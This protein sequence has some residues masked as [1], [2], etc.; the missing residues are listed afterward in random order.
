MKFKLAAFALATLAA[1]SA[2][3]IDGLAPAKPGSAPAAPAAPLQAPAN[4]G[5]VAN[6]PNGNA[7]QRNGIQAN[8]LAADDSAYDKMLY[9]A[10]ESRDVEG[11]KDAIKSGV[12]L[13]Q[14]FGVA[15]PLFGGNLAENHL[16][17][18]KFFVIASPDAGRMSLANVPGHCTKQHLAHA[19]FAASRAFGYGNGIP[20]IATLF[21]RQQ[22]LASELPLANAN[23]RAQLDGEIEAARA[24]Q[25]A[26]F[27]I[28]AL[29]DANIPV[30]DKAF[31]PAYM[32]LNADSM[33]HARLIDLWML[34]KY[35]QA[36]PEIRRARGLKEPSRIAWDAFKAKLAGASGSNPNLPTQYEAAVFDPAA[37]PGGDESATI[38]SFAFTSFKWIEREGPL[39]TQLELCDIEKRIE[40]SKRP[41][42]GFDGELFAAREEFLTDSASM[43]SRK[44]LDAKPFSAFQA[45]ILKLVPSTRGAG[46]LGDAWAQGADVYVQREFVAKLLSRQD[47]VDAM[48]NKTTVP[49]SGLPPLAQLIDA[50]NAFGSPALLRAILE[51]GVNPGLKGNDGKTAADVAMGSGDPQHIW[52]AQAF[53]KKDFDRSGC[54]PSR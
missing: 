15:C 40:M 28:L 23:A 7:I 51:A 41:P 33:S 8:Q 12:N 52:L 10:I 26:S 16:F 32:G 29:L 9:A 39:K 2:M 35:D 11:V 43:L 1:G 38:K 50:S 47:V 34:S 19:Y 54:R 24:K 17:E 30:A 25:A 45:E 18:S 36:L 21:E 49:G 31:Y 6:A 22:F 14:D 3:A 27:E 5:A 42:A 37:L 13:R 48:N 4:A 53:L 44:G 20:S 46:V